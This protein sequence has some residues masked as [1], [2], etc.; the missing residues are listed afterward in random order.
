MSRS[1]HR[2][3]SDIWDPRQDKLEVY[4]D[5]L[6][7]R[8]I[9]KQVKEQRRAYKKEVVPAA[10]PQ[11]I[12]IRVVDLKPHLVFPQL[13][14]IYAVLH[15]LP[16][17][18]LSGLKGIQL[19][20]G[21]QS[22]N[23]YIKFLQDQELM[24]RDLGETS[25]VP[26]PFFGRPSLEVHPGVFRPYSGGTYNR[27][28]QLIQLF[29]F[30]ITDLESLESLDRVAIKFFMFSSLVHELAHH[31]DYMLRVDRGRWLMEDREKAERYARA[32]QKEWSEV[33]MW[34][35]SPAEISDVFLT[36]G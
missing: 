31:E 14:D 8:A 36:S 10:L 22:V 3:R 23:G 7:K 21:I 4:R 20:L 29:G 13:D 19:E 35:L 28:T 26:D 27:D 33:L 25:I 17:G 32:K 12:P 2:T 11:G 5:L 6:E 16:S 15:C 34:D 30:V 1:I 24:P 18:L 9:K